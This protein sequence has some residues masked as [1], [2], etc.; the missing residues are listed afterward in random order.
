MTRAIVRRLVMLVLMLFV[1][2]IVAFLIPYGTGQDPAMAVLR[3]RVAERDPDPEVIEA[4]RV[5][6]GLDQPLVTQY[7]EWLGRALHGDFGV[8]YVSGNEVG[9]LIG[10]ALVVS[11]TLTVVA[12]TVSAIV[13]V[14]LGILAALKPGGRLDNAITALTQTGVA[15]PSYWLGPVAILVFALWLGWLP[16][17]GWKGPAYIILPA[18]TLALRPIAYFT[19]MTR[20][21][22]LDVLSAPYI[23]AARARGLTLYQTI[24]R[25]GLRNSMIPVVTLFA[26]WFAA[27]LG[28]SVVVEVIFAIP[29]MGRLMY[30]G[31]VNADIP[32]IQ[33]GLMAIVGLAIVIN[34][35]TDILYTF[36]NPSIRL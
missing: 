35:A 26:L 13:S 9:D 3:S 34:T 25:H 17:A 16:S 36:L 1:V 30:D 27:L 19:R 14:P 2:S 20:A 18:F 31:V 24:L 22:M 28:G 32:V 11:L 4:I 8:S 23:T 5:E 7:L 6:L 12:L 29:G 33:A 15:I 10:D 21:A